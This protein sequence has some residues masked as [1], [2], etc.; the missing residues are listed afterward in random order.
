MD[1]LT[2]GVATTKDIAF[3]QATY[4]ENI[5]KLHG[6]QRNA[7]YWETQ[8]AERD[9]TYYVVNATTPVAWFRLDEEADELWVGMLQVKP[10]CQRRGVG[11]YVLSVAEAIAK[12]KG[13]EKIGIHT[14]QDNFVARA[15][16]ESA[17]YRVTEIGPCTT[18]DGVERVG[19][20]FQKEISGDFLPESQKGV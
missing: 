15:L 11:R 4:H 13:Y 7:A 6:I 3:I 8:L 2:Y 14:T 16:Y 1:H 20:T 18:A 19:Y 5:D 10:I 9:R 17:G 12:E